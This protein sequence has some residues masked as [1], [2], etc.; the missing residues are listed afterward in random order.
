MRAQSFDERK[1]DGHLD[2]GVEW[3]LFRLHRSRA[4]FKCTAWPKGQRADILDVHRLDGRILTLKISTRSFDRIRA[5]HLLRREE[6]AH[7]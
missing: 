6:S 1:A 5:S 4:C 3:K 2:Q 7:I